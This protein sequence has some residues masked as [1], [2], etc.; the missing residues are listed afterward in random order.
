LNLFEPE[1]DVARTHCSINAFTLAIIAELSIGLVTACENTARGLKQDATGAEA[2]T[3][4]ER[5]HI[6]DTAKD[7]AND[8]AQA[9]RTVG[10]LA[11]DAGEQVAERAAGLKEQVDVKAALMADASVDATRI[12]VDVSARTRTI[13]LN[14]YV[15]T[16]RERANAEAL[17]RARAEGYKVVNNIKVQNGRD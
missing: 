4:D 14:G 6:R 13:T 12:D 16:A 1:D 10:A 15:T 3:R 2:A 5:A 7:V 11:A 8:A 9:A 17:T